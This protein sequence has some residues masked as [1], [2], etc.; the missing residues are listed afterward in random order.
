LLVVESSRIQTAHFLRFVVGSWL[1]GRIACEVLEQASERVE[2]AVSDRD[3][4]LGA[5]L[6]SE[7]LQRRVIPL[8]DKAR[9]V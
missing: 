9:P 3:I 4:E 2:Q 5:K 1:P 8:L 6:S 7:N